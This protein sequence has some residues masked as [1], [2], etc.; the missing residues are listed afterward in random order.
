MKTENCKCLKISSKNSKVKVIKNYDIFDDVPHCFSLD[1]Y[2]LN[3]I[4]LA[5]WYFPTSNPSHWCSQTHPSRL[6]WFG[7]KKCHTWIEAVIEQL[8]NLGML[9]RWRDKGEWICSQVG[10]VLNKNRGRG[11]FWWKS[12][13]DAFIVGGYG[14]EG[15]RWWME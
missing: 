11:W 12:C 14:V 4:P 2:R 8:R 5:S 1:I 15:R 3:C 7:A 6:N 10:M 9:W 13:G